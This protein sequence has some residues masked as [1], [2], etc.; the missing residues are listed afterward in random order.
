MKRE[1]QI[2]ADTCYEC[3]NY[4]QARFLE[5]MEAQG[6]KRDDPEL[7]W[8]LNNWEFDDAGPMKKDVENGEKQSS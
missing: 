8:L 6:F 5:L 2:A 7:E 3:C 4:N 1:M